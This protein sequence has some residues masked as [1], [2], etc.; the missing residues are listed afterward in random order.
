MP[1]WSAPPQE[2]LQ[3]TLGEVIMALE[4]EVGSNPS[5]LEVVGVSNESLMNHAANAVAEF[6]RQDPTR[7]NEI[8]GLYQLYTLGFV[9]GLKYGEHRTTMKGTTDATSEEEES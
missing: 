2:R 6:V 9:V 7:L 5:F 8:D 3:D 4:R 1:K